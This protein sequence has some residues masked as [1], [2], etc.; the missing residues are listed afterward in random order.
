MPDKGETYV[1]LAKHITRWGKAKS[2]GFN[3]NPFGEINEKIRWLCQH[4]D[5]VKGTDRKGRRGA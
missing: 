5:K 2:K 3:A 4:L 1:K